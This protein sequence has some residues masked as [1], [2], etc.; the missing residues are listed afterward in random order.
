MYLKR[1]TLKKMKSDLFDNKVKKNIYF[2]LNFY[3]KLKIIS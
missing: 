3:L 2:F 1:V